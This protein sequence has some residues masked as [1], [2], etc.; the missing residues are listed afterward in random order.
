[1]AA[2][3]YVKV[4]PNSDIVLFS[5]NLMVFMAFKKSCSIPQLNSCVLSLIVILFADY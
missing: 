3:N 5:E 1:M 4:R 2:P